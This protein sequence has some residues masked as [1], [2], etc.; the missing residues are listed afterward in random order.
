MDGILVMTAASPWDVGGPSSAQ[1]A[2]I[3]LCCY[4]CVI[5]KLRLRKERGNSLV[6]QTIGELTSPEVTRSSPCKNLMPQL[7]RKNKSIFVALFLGAIRLTLETLLEEEIR[8][9]VGAK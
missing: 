3:W 6:K 8:R 7:K 4:N 5:E 9:I 2:Q 1:S